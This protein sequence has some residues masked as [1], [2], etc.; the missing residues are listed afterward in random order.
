MNYKF[1]VTYRFASPSAG[2]RLANS[3][4]YD[5]Q[6]CRDI[7]GVS[8]YQNGHEVNAQNGDKLK[9]ASSLMKTCSNCEL[10]KKF[11]PVFYSPRYFN[12]FIIDNDSSIMIHLL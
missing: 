3:S 12:I 2:Q 6:K 11:V 7:V 10:S 1:N 4:T 9:P 8:S 5:C